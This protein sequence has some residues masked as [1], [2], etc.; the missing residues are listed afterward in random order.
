M[1]KLC[2]VLL[3]VI[4]IVGSIASFLYLC[5]RNRDTLGEYYAH[6]SI[7]VEI[8]R[9]YAYNIAIAV[10]TSPNPCSYWLSPT[11]AVDNSL[12]TVVMHKSILLKRPFWNPA[13]QFPQED[14]EAA[15]KAIDNIAFFVGNKL[16]YFSH[17]DVRKFSRADRNGYTFFY[18]PGIYY[19]KSLVFKKWSNYYGD[20]NFGI[21]AL[22]ALLLYPARFAPVYLLLFLL[23]FMY[24]KQAAAFYTA[25]KNKKTTVVILLIIIVAAGF[26]L[27]WNGYTRHSG[28]TDE[29]Y[30]AVYAGSPMK[31]FMSTFID[32]GNPPFY[33]ILLRFWFIIFGWS[34]ETGTMLSVLLGTFSILTVY[35][36]VK[37][38]LGGKAAF[39]AA[40]FTAFSGFSIGYSQEMRGYVLKMALA[41]LI[42]LS[43]F[44]YI[45]KPSLKNLFFYIVLS[46]MIVNT[47][48]YGILFIMANF[49]FY[50]ALA[51]YRRQWRWKTAMFF[52]AGNVFICISFLPYF[53]YMLLVMDNDFSREFS[54]G[55]GHFFVFLVIIL[56]SAAFFIFRKEIAKKNLEAKIL[57]DDQIPFAAY[58]LILPAFIFTLA[59]LIS[60]VKPLIAF[61]YLW[62]I[63]APFCFALASAIIFSVHKLQKWRFIT[64]LL[65]YMYVIG[66][67]GIIPDIPS[68]GTEGYK[69][70]RAYIAADAEAHPG[71][72]AVMLDNAPL[73]AAY[74]GFPNLPSFA[75]NAQADIIYIYNDIFRM[76]EMEM[77]DELKTLNPDDGRMLKI[78]FD[79]EYPREDG[80]VI[81]KY[82]PASEQ[83]RK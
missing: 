33:F 35:L 34:E 50:I 52:L 44:H 32:P 72:K 57:R 61:R 31:P 18:I 56:F 19:E 20:L 55:I 69:Q 45:N 4:C 70:A 23:L 54:P 67:N 22:T 13:I 5:M 25:V 62:P 42:S 43:L 3:T 47:H 74:Y 73:N 49:L 59:F 75:Q 37:P 17:E 39:C 65:V 29:I 68:G 26:A 15:L 10:E 46:I 2:K 9:Q 21:K 83:D 64:P 1:K 58:L 41:P 6:S 82:L 30:S 38:F 63:S 14:A 28:W 11:T 12:K 77:Y 60:F 24:R 78:I 40:L 76:H 71:K 79:Y 36:M 80:N 53:L 48:I 16:Y 27:R 81:F 7:N 66:L 51:L 8:D